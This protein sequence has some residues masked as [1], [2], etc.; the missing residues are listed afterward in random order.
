MRS[1][2]YLRLSFHI[3]KGVLICAVLFPWIDTEKRRWH[4]RRWSIR[5]LQLCRIKVEI[6][7][8]SSGYPT[9]QMVISNHVSWL[10]IYAIN[11]W[12]PVRFVA[13]SE[14]RDWPV[15]GWLWE[16][17]GTLFIERG[18]RKAAHHMLHLLAERLQAGDAICVFPEGATGDG[19]AI[20]PFHSNLMQAPLS[21]SAPVLPVGVRY[22]DARTREPAASAAYVGDMSL[23]AILKGPPLVARVYLG[24]PILAE[25]GVDRRVLAGQGRAAISHLLGLPPADTAPG[26][27]HA[28]QDPDPV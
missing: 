7:G 9:G 24:R 21:A 12:H 19:T 2:R 10:D 18:K 15:I 23:S 14:I 8:D 22:L 28:P 17:T 11:A 6:V 20:L 26:S 5:I 16:K 1:L 27:T 13:K 25:E 3:L 4:I